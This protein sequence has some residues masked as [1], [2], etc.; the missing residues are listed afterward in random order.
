VE[1]K[2]VIFALD[3]EQA[4]EEG[5][6][7]GGGGCVATMEQEDVVSLVSYRCPDS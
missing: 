3:G 4:T 1:A 2:E 5:G 6:M 7:G